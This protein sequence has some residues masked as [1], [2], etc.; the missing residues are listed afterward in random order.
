MG[1]LKNDIFRY[2][3]LKAKL[4]PNNDMFVVMENTDDWKE[5][6]LLTIKL[7]PILRTSKL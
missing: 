2:K 4:N 7:M 5:F 1:K 3:E 6:N